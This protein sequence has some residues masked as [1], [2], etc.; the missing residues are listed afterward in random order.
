MADSYTNTQRIAKNT[1]ILYFR[2]AVTMLVSLYASRVVLNSLGVSDYG[3]Y[4]VVGGVVGM[5]SLLSG[6][7]SAAISRFLT[8]EIGKG[9]PE[10]INEVFSVSCVVQ[11][12][13]AIGVILIMEIVGVWFL[14]TQMNIP[15]DRMYA[16]NW[17]LQCSFFSFAVG[18]VSVPYNALIVAREKMNVMAYISIIETF[19]HLAVVLSLFI[20]PFDKLI[21][22][23]VLLLLVAIFIRFV[24]VIYCKKHFVESHFRLVKNKES[25]LSIFSFAGWNFFSQGSQLLNTLGTNLLTN[26]FFG[27]EVNAARAIAVQVNKSIRQFINSFMIAVNP[28]ITKSYAVGELSYMHSLICRSAKFSFFVMLFFAIPIWMETPFILKLWLNIVP[29]Y[30]VVFVRLILVAALCT[31]LTYPIDTAQAATGKVKKA[32]IVITMWSSL[33][34]PLTWLAFYL[35]TSPT[36]YYFLYIIVYFLL[37]FIKLYLVAELI[38]MKM[39]YFLMKVLFKVSLIALMAIVP[40]YLL[41]CILK[42]GLLRFL[43]IGVISVLW[44]SVVIYFIGLDRMEKTFLYQQIQKRIKSKL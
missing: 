35:G 34:F 5:F 36:A 23:G 27:V 17:V 1:I 13:L 20:S 43:V 2:M 32:S 21:F 39:R 25:Y 6:S 3:I 16:A 24:N 14:N 10:K 37:I 29:T 15:E 33:V 30:T 38:Q 31:V 4:N 8:Y 19:L 26:I 40:P 12:G 22:Y 42:A 41:L 9:N 11:A 28:Q 7:L 44:T 18:L